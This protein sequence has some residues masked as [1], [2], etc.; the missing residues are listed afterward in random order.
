MMRGIILI[1]NAI[2]KTNIP[3][4]IMRG[5]V[6]EESQDRALKAEVTRP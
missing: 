5:W 2:L 4:G 3:G 1:V 6:L